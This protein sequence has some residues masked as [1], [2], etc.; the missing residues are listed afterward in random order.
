MAE[1]EVVAQHFTEAGLAIEAIGYWRKAG[2]LAS[3]RWA[4]REAVSSARRLLR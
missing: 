4:N 2:Q 3:A 1:P